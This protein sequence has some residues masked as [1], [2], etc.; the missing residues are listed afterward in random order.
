MTVARMTPILIPKHLQINPTALDAAIN[1]AVDGEAESI[2][3]D[4]GRAS[5]DFSEPPNFYIQKQ[6]K[7]GR[8]IATRD[9]EFAYTTEGTKG[10]YPIQ[11]HGRTLAFRANYQRKTIIGR[12][13]TRPGGGSGPTVY[14]RQVIHPGIEGTHVN[15]TIAEEHERPFRERLEKELKAALPTK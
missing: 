12:A 2:K 10:P 5:A 6:G 14:T 7:Y 4:Y 11:A 13:A 15:K 3:D 8:L 1:R 9:E